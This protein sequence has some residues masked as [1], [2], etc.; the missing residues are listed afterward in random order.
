MFFVGDK[1]K[2]RKE[3]ATRLGIPK[4]LVYTVR[5]SDFGQVVVN[6][7][8]SQWIDENHFELVDA[9]KPKETRQVVE[10]AGCTITVRQPEGE[11]LWWVDV[12]EGDKYVW[13]DS[14]ETKK[15]A[16]SDAKYVARK[17]GRGEGPCDR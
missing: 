2:L 8:R 10:Q 16:L 11:S 17:H 9:Y 1:V 6:G 7:L 15:A 4:D 3:S 12:F 14:Y 13:S 5:R